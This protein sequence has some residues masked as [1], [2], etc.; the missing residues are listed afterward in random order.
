MLAMVTGSGMM[1][2]AADDAAPP[3]ASPPAGTAASSS[4]G[5][6]SQLQAEN[7]LGTLEFL[8]NLPPERL[9]ALRKALE[10]IEKMPPAEREALR[11]EIQTRQLDINQ[12]NQTLRAEVQALSQA[13]RS[14]LRQYLVRLFTEQLAAL[15]AKVADAKTSD[16]RKAIITDLLKA[17]NDLGI[18]PEAERPPPGGRNGRGNG[19]GGI[20]VGGPRGNGPGRPMPAPTDSTVTGSAR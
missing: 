10:S 14:V 12:I 11:V 8:L 2:M 16:D 13:D 3:A 18:K 15:K 4:T 7:D 17:A 1:V 5:G 19:P 20:G 9:T 6:N